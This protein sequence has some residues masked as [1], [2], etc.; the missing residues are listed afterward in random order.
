MKQPDAQT[1][2]KLIDEGRTRQQIADMYHVSICTIQNRIK[3]FNS[4]AD[5]TKMVVRKPV[6]LVDPPKTKDLAKRTEA[7]QKV[8]RF[9]QYHMDLI[10]MRQGVDK[11]DVPGLY[12]RFYNY[13]AYCAERG[14]MPNNMNC[15]FAIG[16]SKEDIFKWH[17]GEWGT[18][19]HRGFADTVR[20]FFASVH[21]QAPTDGLM[22][23]I[24]AMFWQ[25]AHDGMVE[26]SKVEV[27][28]KDPLGDKQSA[29]E[30]A[31]KYAEYA[32]PDD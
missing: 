9:V 27:I 30:I 14:I 7:E 11:K 17:T 1:V 4:D 22:N 10:K 23:P 32:L 3:K 28:H 18:P 24:S 6:N 8:G 21:E 19:E 12:Q 16:V 25:K 29:E 13:L 31:A 20:D 2:L 5:Y 15:Y 26:A